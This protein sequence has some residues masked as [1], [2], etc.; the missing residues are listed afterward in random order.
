[1]GYNKR[2]ARRR[3]VPVA[4]LAAQIFEQKKQQFIIDERGFIRAKLLIS[5]LST[6]SNSKEN[7]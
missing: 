2:A 5:R 1:M 4:Q 3:D 6:D 7:A